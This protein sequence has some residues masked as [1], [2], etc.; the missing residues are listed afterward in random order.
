MKKFKTL[1]AILTSLLFFALITSCGKK[2]DAK[3]EEG[4]AEGSAAVATL[5]P[6]L[7][8]GKEAFEMNCASCHGEKG[9]GDGPGG[10]N[11]NPKPRDYRLPAE[12]WKNGP[13]AEGITKTLNE[14]IPG[15]GMVP[16]KHLG[17]ET[18]QSLAKYVMH[19]HE[20]K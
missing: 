19:L 15:S 7:E 14:G 6:E 11:L 10:A 16:Y 8:K 18:I 1:S 4:K 2:E 20:G 13:T 3:T 17:D 12:Q 5:S 9:A